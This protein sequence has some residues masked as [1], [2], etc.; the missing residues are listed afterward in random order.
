MS[1]QKWCAQTSGG[2]STFTDGCD[3]T[4]IYSV[5]AIRDISECMSLDKE[6]RHKKRLWRELDD[7]SSADESLDESSISVK[8][9]IRSEN[10][11]LELT[12]DFSNL[13]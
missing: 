13:R 4:S 8:G 5:C 9:E 12:S 3:L 11:E 6:T 2:L 1:V 10:T 7:E